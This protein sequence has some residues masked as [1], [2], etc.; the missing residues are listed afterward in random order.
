MAPPQGHMLYTGLYKENHEKI[1]M[2]LNH[3]AYSLDI[4]Y[5]ASPSKPLPSLFKLCH[6][7]PKWPRARSRQ[8]HGQLSTDTYMYALNN[9]QVSV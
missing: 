9:N 3:K 8:G 4:W 5:V 6:R 2:S 1:F 7:G